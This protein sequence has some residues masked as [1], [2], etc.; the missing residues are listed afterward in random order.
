MSL[1]RSELESAARQAFPPEILVPDATSSWT[2]LTDMGWWAMTVPEA[3]GGL[4]LGETAAAVIQYAMGAALVPGPAIAQMLVIEALANSSSSES[5]RSYL[6]RAMTGTVMTAAL[7]GETNAVLRAVPDADKASHILHVDKQDVALIAM[8]APGLSFSSRPT[9]D[10][11]RRLFDVILPPEAPRLVLASGQAGLRLTTRLRTSLHQALAADSLGAAETLLGLTVDYLMTRRQFDRPLAMFQAL[12]H[13]VADHRMALSAAQALLWRGA[14][15][16]NE[17]P[18]RCAALKAH[19]CRVA[20]EIAEDSVQL[21]GGIGLTMEH[22]C[23]L[24]LKRA[25]LNAAL[26]GSTDLLEEEVGR[27]RLT[28]LA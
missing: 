7:G 5:A 8:D 11:T 24:F 13:R 25:L 23:H 6:Q 19:A 12:K 3:H 17:Q 22:H 14:G 20:V 15:D 18:T 2:A 10:R 26:G 27:A 9:W 1:D 21:H 4:G 16:P 28:G